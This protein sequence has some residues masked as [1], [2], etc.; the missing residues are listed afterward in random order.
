[1]KNEKRKLASLLKLFI[2]LAA[3]F[4]LTSSEAA[5]RLKIEVW[6]DKDELL[7]HEPIVVHYA[8]TNVGDST[9]YL[10]FHMIEEDFVV[11]DEN[12]NRYRSHIRGTY[13]GGQLFIPG[14][15]YTGNL[16][17]GG[18][19][20]VNATGE[21]TC[22]VHSYPFFC[23]DAEF[24]NSNTIKFKVV[25]P[26]GEEERALNLFLEA[27]KLEWARS[28]T[29]GPDSSKEAIAFVK[30]QE[31]VD[32]YPR[33][34]YAPKALNGAVGVYFYSQNLEQ[35]RR[36]IPVCI[37]LIEEYPNSYYF[38]LAFTE[39]LH[40]YEMVKDKEEATKILRD[41]IKKHPNTRISEE[42]ERR[43]KKVEK[44]EFE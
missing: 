30:Y 19:Y 32:R 35:R 24:L 43:L 31:L 23:S 40:T 37:R 39:L 8:V 13:G 38:H 20:G 29:G 1:M 9:A 34:V 28:E 25:R 18:R 6:I 27:E 7:T 41:L 2:I 26:T 33:S 10:N 3:F 36:V 4:L 44:W 15:T 14:E 22:Y 42:A 11:E 5:E 21:Y 12:G 16:D 17:I